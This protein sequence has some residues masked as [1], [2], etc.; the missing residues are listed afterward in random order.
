MSNNRI[1]ESPTLN[2]SCVLGLALESMLLADL[3][4]TLFQQPARPA[5][6]VWTGNNEFAYALVRLGGRR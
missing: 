5:R 2:Q 3:A 1:L 4:K 6:E